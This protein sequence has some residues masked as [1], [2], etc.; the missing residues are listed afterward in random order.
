MLIGEI[1]KYCDENYSLKKCRCFDCDHPGECPGDCKECLRQIHFQ[2]NEDDKRH[3]Y[4]C[5]NLA[6]CYVCKYAFK[7]TSEMCRALKGIERLSCAS[8]LRV[9][10]IGCGPCTDLFALDCL[11]KKGE[12]SFRKINYIGVEPLETWKKIHSR[13]KCYDYSYKVF[14]MYNYIQYILPSLIEDRFEADIIIMNYLLSDFHKYGGEE[15]VLDF[16]DCLVYYIINV[17]P[18]AVIVINDINLCCLKG[19][20]RDYYDKLFDKIKKLG[21]K[22]DRRHF[23]NSNKPN[24]FDYGDEYPSNELIFSDEFISEYEYY[25]P[26]RSCASAQI[27]IYKGAN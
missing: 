14:F 15:N 3:S 22:C 23:F 21:Y 2:A 6:N 25:E 19:G 20:G 8:E 10:S 26:Y 5:K 27:I 11:K 9:L 7:Y 18:N 12:Y 16:L 1:L 17:S 4:N 13:I 24:H